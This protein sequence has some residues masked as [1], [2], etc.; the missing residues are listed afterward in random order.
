MHKYDIII[1]T[2]MIIIPFYYY[3]ISQRYPFPYLNSL[4]FT[5][6]DSLLSM[7]VQRII[8]GKRSESYSISKSQIYIINIEYFLKGMVIVLNFVCFSSFTFIFNIM[9]DN[10]VV[11]FYTMVTIYTDSCNKVTI[12][13]KLSFIIITLTLYK[14]F[15]TESSNSQNSN[16]NPFILLLKSFLIAVSDI[17]HNVSQK[18]HLDA[19]CHFNTILKKC[20]FMLIPSL[21][22]FLFFEN[23]SLKSIK[24]NFTFDYLMHILWGLGTTQ[25]MRIALASSNHMLQSNFAL[26]YIQLKSIPCLLL[27][28]IFCSRFELSSLQLLAVGLI[29]LLSFIFMF[30]FQFKYGKAHDSGSTLISNSDSLFSSEDIEHS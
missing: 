23:M 17:L 25:I 21:L 8:S 29:P 24:Q 27:Y 2:G 30:F 1:F 16:T 20:V 19:C 28:Y 4:V 26:L 13:A 3:A 7:A 6:L 18:K 15:C 9:F 11:T 10:I 22:S 5:I 12:Y 14:L